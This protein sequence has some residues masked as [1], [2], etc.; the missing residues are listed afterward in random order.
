MLSGISSTSIESSMSIGSGCVS[1][2]V[3]GSG[4]SPTCTAF[5]VFFDRAAVFALGSSFATGSFAAGL[6]PLFA[7]AGACAS[8]SSCTCT[9]CTF[10]GLPLFV[11]FGGATTSSSPNSSTSSVSL[12]LT[13]LR[14]A[15]ALRPA[16]AGAF[17]AT[18][19]LPF[20]TLN[21]LP[22]LA[23]RVVGLPLAGALVAGAIALGC[24]A[25]PR[26]LRVGALFS[27]LDSGVGSALSSS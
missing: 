23:R 18:A 7:G 19:E 9:C 3:M 1:G 4:S 17:F 12:P 8:S 27:A 25:L 24:A 16:L 2:I 22:P 26:A 21:T 15:S 13:S 11:V 5:F 10:A 6:R 14:S 20:L